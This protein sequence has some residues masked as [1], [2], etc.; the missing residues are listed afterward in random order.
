MSLLAKFAMVRN[1]TPIVAAQALSQKDWY[2]FF[3]NLYLS[4]IDGLPQ[5]PVAITV[6]ASPFVY[7]A[8]IRGQL[9]VDGGT[10]SAIEFSRDGGTTWFDAGITAGFVQM[11]SRDQARITYTVLPTVNYFPM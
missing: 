6:T 7:T 5:S 9:H 4:A 11:D 8:V 3:Y 10:V 2:I 1:Q